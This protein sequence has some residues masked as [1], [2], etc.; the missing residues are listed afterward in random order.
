MERGEIVQFY[1]TAQKPGV[2]NDYSV[3]ATWK[4]CVNGYYLL[5]LWRDKVEAPTLE[6]IVVANYNKWLPNKIVIEDKS[7]GSSL[8]QYLQHNT[9][10]PVV[11]V[12]PTVDK[13]LRAIDATPMQETGNLYLPENA[14]W[15]ADFQI[16]H[17][18]FPNGAHDDQ[19]DTTGMMA[20]YFR[21]LNNYRPRV[22]RL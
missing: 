15:L 19:V 9:T 7:S 6:K 2:T 14:K 5:D 20:S 4:K 17:D 12:D 13:V 16:E 22:R 18:Q 10:L 8:I 21:K 3:C 11:P 1:D